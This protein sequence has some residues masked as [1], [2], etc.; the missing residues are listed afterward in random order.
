MN[1]MVITILGTIATL[2]SVPVAGQWISYPT[3][4][5]PRLANGKMNAAAPVPRTADGKPDLSG[6][7]Y[8]APRGR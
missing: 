6:L 1:R 8:S 5:L 4:G 2:A 3:P 7:W